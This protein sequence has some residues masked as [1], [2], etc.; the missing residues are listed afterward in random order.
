MTTEPT[1][2]RSATPPSGG[3][4][5]YSLAAT[6][7]TAV[8]NLVIH[9]VVNSTGVSFVVAFGAGDKTMHITAAHVAALSVVP[10]L[11]ASALAVVASRRSMSTLRAVQLVAGV[12]A[13][14]SLGGPLSLTAELGAKVA[15]ASMHVVAGVAF[16]LVVERARRP[17]PDNT[18]GS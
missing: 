17:H 10:L 13:V 8:V 14:V 1:A 16:V 15:L 18:H 5:Q 6:A 12:V 2:L 3:L 4:W 7:V 11:I 9:T